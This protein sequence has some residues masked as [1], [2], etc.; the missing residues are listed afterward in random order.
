MQRFARIKLHA[1][2]LEQ[3]KPLSQHQVNPF[4]FLDI[5]S[6]CATEINSL[7]EYIV[8][9]PTTESRNLSLTDWTLVICSVITFPKLCQFSILDSGVASTWQAMIERERATF[10]AHIDRLCD[11]LE[12]I[13][14]AKRATEKKLPDLFYLF[15][16][17]LRLFKDNQVREVQRLPASQTSPKNNEQSN[18]RRR[19]RCPVING[20]IQG[21]DYWTMWMNS[22]NF[23]SDEELFSVPGGGLPEFD[24]ND[25]A[26]FDLNSWID[27]SV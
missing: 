9:I 3:E 14:V 19:S 2:P 24:M 13:S 15:C 7:L 11:R 10:L 12:S 25:P 20:D 26:V 17:V 6:V 1:L 16:T 27:F 4:T 5:F 18:K 8:K 21:T 22:N 23:I